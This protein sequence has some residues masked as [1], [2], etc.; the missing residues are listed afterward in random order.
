MPPG[1]TVPFSVRLPLAGPSF[2]TVGPISTHVLVVVWVPLS[3]LECLLNG[4][5]EGTNEGTLKMKLNWL[6]TLTSTLSDLWFSLL[7]YS[8]A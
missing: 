8:G 3:F 5:S 2:Y 1:T 6:R 4:E 7:F